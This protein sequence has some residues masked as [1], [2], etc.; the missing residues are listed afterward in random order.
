MAFDHKFDSRALSAVLTDFALLGDFC[1][2]QLQELL[3]SLVFQLP[4][5]RGSGTAW[6]SV[7]GVASLLA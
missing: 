3:S 4:Q 1:S 6:F 7:E 2:S 5:F